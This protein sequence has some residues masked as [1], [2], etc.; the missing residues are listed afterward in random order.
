MVS[1]CP[2]CQHQIDDPSV[3]CQQ[4][5]WSQPDAVKK[6]GQDSLVSTEPNPKPPNPKPPN[7]KRPAPPTVA[8]RQPAATTVNFEQTLDQAMDLIEQQ[9]YASALTFLN[10]A[11]QDAPA[12]RLAECY[13]VRGFAHLKN[14]DFIRAEDDC[15]EAIGLNW[16]QAQ[17]YAWR[18]AA[19][20]EQNKWRLAFDDLD[21][22]CELAGSGRDQY[23]AL[24]ES[25]AETASDYF[26][27]QITNGND[28]ADLFFERGWIYLRCGKYQK[29]ERDFQHAFARQEGHPWASVGLAELL[30][31]Q[32]E[33][34]GVR[35]LCE[36]G[37]N[38]GVTCRRRAL[39]IRAQLNHA[40]GNIGLAQTDLDLLEELAQDEPH[41]LVDCARLRSKI[42]DQVAAIDELT[43]L[44]NQS[45]DHYLAFWCAVIVLQKFEIMDWQ[46]KTTLVTCASI[47]RI[48]ACRFAEPECFW[49][50]NAGWRFM[51]I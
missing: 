14:L 50:P 15:T 20:G 49:V 35:E 5:G 7:A 48:Y 38:G 18:A 43:R 6:P 19:R 39:E 41:E 34:A 46:S 10:R 26:R 30:L 37:L 40:V 45:S 13:S 11:I 29:S 36:F 8:Q 47:R 16:Q 3:P 24:M 44:L 42:G 4:C 23:L 17:T 2:Q 51:R 28:S 1:Q 32:S 25:Y 22:A 27:E 31:H 21:R 9:D 33:T 12:Q